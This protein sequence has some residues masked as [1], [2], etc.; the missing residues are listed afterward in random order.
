MKQ[1]AFIKPAFD[2]FARTLAQPAHQIPG[3]DHGGSADIGNQPPRQAGDRRPAIRSFFTQPRA[4]I[5]DRL[6]RVQR[7]ARNA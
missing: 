3:L 6:L 4:S 7:P 5:P 2:A 1:P